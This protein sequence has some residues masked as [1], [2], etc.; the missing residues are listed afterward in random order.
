MINKL[1]NKFEFFEKMQFL[2]IKMR[3]IYKNAQKPDCF[4]L[5]W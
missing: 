1:V 4:L 5:K 3:L 2:M